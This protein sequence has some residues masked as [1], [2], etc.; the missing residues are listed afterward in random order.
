MGIK[1][2]EARARGGTALH[3]DDRV[4]LTEQKRSE[5]GAILSSDAGYENGSE[6]GRE[7]M[8]AARGGRKGT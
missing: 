8:G 3:P 7:Y 2:P 5:L 6:H 4:A 1:E